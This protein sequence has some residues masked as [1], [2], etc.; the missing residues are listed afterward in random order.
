MTV[1]DPA[2]GLDYPADIAVIE[3]DAVFMV[4]VARVRD[5]FVSFVEANG[6]TLNRHEEVALVLDAFAVAA[7]NFGRRDLTPLV[8]RYLAAPTGAP[9]TLARYLLGVG[10]VVRQ[11]RGRSWRYV[12]GPVP[13]KVL[14]AAALVAPLHRPR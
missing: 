14:A 10:V 8:R 11:R 4:E 9:R 1:H 13:P 7:V 2:L 3:A 5:V 6:E 12:L